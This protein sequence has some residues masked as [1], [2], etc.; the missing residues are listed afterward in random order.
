MNMKLDDQQINRIAQDLEA[1]FK[2]Y[3]NRDTLEFRSVLDWDDLIDPEFWEEDLQKI[4]KEWKDYAVLT[5]LESREAFRIME[6]FAYEVDDERLK[7]NLIKILNRRSP[8][9]NFRAEIDDSDYR[10]QW[11]DFRSKKTEEYVKTQLKLENIPFE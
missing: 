3:I 4:E 9:A 10:Q 5:K 1:G 8:F 6:D 7:E 11:F 2:V